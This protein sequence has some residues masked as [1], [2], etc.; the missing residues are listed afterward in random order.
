MPIT[1]S[2]L[3][4][5]RSAPTGTIVGTLTARDVGSV[6]PCN[7]ILSKN[8]PAISPFHPTISL[9]SGAGQLHRAIIRCGSAQSG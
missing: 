5:A 3:T 6:I 9:Q 4:V 2:N 1:I 8:P 7:F